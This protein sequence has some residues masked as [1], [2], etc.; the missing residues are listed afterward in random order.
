MNVTLVSDD[1]VE[2]LLQDAGFRAQWTRLYEQCRWAT[3]MQSL[4]FVETWYQVYRSLYAPL[5]AIG[6]DDAGALLGLLPLAVERASRR[7]IVAGAQYAEYKTWVAAES[8]GDSFIAEALDR[9]GAAFPDQTLPFLFLAP[10]SPLGWLSRR[11][12]SGRTDLRPLPRPLMNVQDVSALKDSLRKKGN[13]S[14]INQMERL[15]RLSLVQLH[16]PAELAAVFDELELQAN[17]RL[18]AI[19]DFRPGRD[20]LKKAFYVALMETGMVHATLLKI[21]EDIASGHVNLR[22]RDEVLLGMTSFSPLYGGYSPSKFHIMLLG[23]ELA[24]QQVT[25]FDLTPGGEY[26]DRHATHHDEAY[27]LTVFFNRAA[28]LRRRA[29]R[30]LVTVAKRA[31]TTLG[32]ERDQLAARLG[33]ARRKVAGIGSAGRSAL[34]MQRTE[35]RVYALTAE[36]AAALPP[37][38]LLQRNGIADLL[39][40]APTEPWQPPI[41]TFHQEALRRLETGWTVFTAAEGGRLLW[42]GWVSPAREKVSLGGVGQEW[43]PP[44]DAAALVDCYVEAGNPGLARD[45]LSQMA[46]WAASRPQVRQVQVAVAA[47]NPALR[48]AVEDAGGA[49]LGSFYKDQKLGRTRRW[50]SY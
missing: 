25:A 40:Y 50:S 4:P 21:G 48:S 6:V 18:S 24:G 2:R 19:H 37:A 32:I 10:R 7:L 41:R 8:Q 17:L 34:T 42:Y 9:L 47:A 1:A 33:A 38:E 26:K 5:L 31:L 16:Q 22:N 14:R 28:Y 35:V 46:Q 27:A 13:R 45:G 49:Y 44:E 12:W 39:A 36:Q 15:G 43:Q 11:G 30:G 20:P 3:S 23:L 29:R